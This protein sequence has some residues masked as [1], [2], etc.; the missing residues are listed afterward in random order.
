MITATCTNVD[1]RENGVNYNV[2]GAPTAVECGFC[3]QPCELTD[4]RP[5]PT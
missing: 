1:C 5:D 4:E 2:E 3:A